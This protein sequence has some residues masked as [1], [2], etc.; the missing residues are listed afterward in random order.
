MAT[1]P[2]ALPE[3]I[4]SIHM[5]LSAKDAARSES[6]CRA[7]HSVR[8]HVDVQKYGDRKMRRWRSFANNVCIN[9]RSA[10]QCMDLRQWL[11]A[12]AG[13]FRAPVHGPLSL[14]VLVED[15]AA[16]AVLE[17]EVG[18]WLWTSARRPKRVLDLSLSA[19]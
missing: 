7:W 3:C 5:A 8:D 9:K 4:V 19:R 13:R 18:V 10:P 6:V 16:R 15:D 1:S 14:E 2:L 17:W 12:H 11:V